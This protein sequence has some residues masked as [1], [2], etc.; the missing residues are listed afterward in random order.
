MLMRNSEVPFKNRKKVAF[1]ARLTL[2]R[3]GVLRVHGLRGK[4]N[5]A[6][7]EPGPGDQ[8]VRLE[9]GDEMGIGDHLIRLESA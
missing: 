3:D 6:A 7:S 4:S 9:R 2:D 8:W 1:H 5:A